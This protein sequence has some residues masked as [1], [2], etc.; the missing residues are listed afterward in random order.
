[1]PNNQDMFQNPLVTLIL[2]MLAGT[3][4]PPDR[5]NDLG[6]VISSLQAAVKSINTGMEMFHA[7]V[8]PMFQKR[9][10]DGN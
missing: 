1:M 2:L 3:A 9:P 4:A 10:G 6:R 7:E 5:L 8:M